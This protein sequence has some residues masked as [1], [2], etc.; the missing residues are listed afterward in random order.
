MNIDWPTAAV[1]ISAIGIVAGVFLRLYTTSGNEKLKDIQKRLDELF[2]LL[3]DSNGNQGLIS[4]VRVLEALEK[5]R[6]GD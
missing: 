3:N 5:K 2:K 6:Q 1:L 4:R